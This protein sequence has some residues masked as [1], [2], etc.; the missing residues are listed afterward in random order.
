MKSL[1]LLLIFTA[2]ILNADKNW[3][4]IKTTD[5]TQKVQTKPKLDLSQ[6]Q[7]INKMMKNLKIV[8]ELIDNTKKEKVVTND[9]NWF[10]LNSKESN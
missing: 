6:I 7:P 3:I 5:K 8:K 2:L 4:E 9:K 1:I 10:V